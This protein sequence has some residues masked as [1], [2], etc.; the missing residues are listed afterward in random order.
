MIPSA[1]ASALSDQSQLSRHIC[2]W[3]VMD[4]QFVENSLE[5]RP[6]VC[7]ASSG[8]YVD[9]C[10]DELVDT[11]SLQRQ[12]TILRG[13]SDIVSSRHGRPP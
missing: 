10:D 4:S 1:T 6:V 5:V 7:R 13:V 8:L 2:C 12:R 11:A 9:P 3:S